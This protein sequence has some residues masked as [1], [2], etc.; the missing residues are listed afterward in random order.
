MADEPRLPDL[1]AYLDA[2]LALVDLPLEPELR[3]RVLLHLGLAAAMAGEVMTFPL[4]DE[5][6]P[7]PVYQP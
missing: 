1:P 3:P 4:S 2:A 6:E 7:A 5:A